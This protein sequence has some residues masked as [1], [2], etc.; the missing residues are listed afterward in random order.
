MKKNLLNP[1]A[2]SYFDLNKEDQEDKFF[3]N[4]NLIGEE[5]KDLFEKNEKFIDNHIIK[6]SPLKKRVNKRH[7]S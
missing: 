7:I 4:K 5:I 3:E 1:N 2:G 6:K